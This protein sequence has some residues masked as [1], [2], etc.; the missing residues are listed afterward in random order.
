MASLRLVKTE[1]IFLQRSGGSG[2]VLKTILSLVGLHQI[3]S[4]STLSAVNM[5]SVL[6]QPTSTDLYLINLTFTAGLRSGMTIDEVM[7]LVSESYDKIKLSEEYRKSIESLDVD[8]KEKLYR[9]IENKPL[10]R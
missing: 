1:V 2:C 3:D 5:R 10:G 9:S 6:G 8:T 7:P 4:D